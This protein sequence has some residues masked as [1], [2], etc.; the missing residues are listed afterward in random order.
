MDKMPN[1]VKT[2]GDD[3]LNTSLYISDPSIIGSKL[4]DDI[5]SIDSYESISKEGNATGFRLYANWGTMVVN[6]MPSVQLESHLNDFCHYIR[7]QIE[8]NDELTY[9][10][11]RLHY[12]LM[13]LGC[14]IE[15]DDQDEEAVHAFLFEFNMRLNGLM[16]LHDTVWDW[17]GDV[18]CSQYEEE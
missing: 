4:F 11:G 8:D 13:V 5:V 10:L 1:T 12:V 9:A 7:S 6:I 17:T 2:Q 14:I 16:F 3:I 18:L 15:Y